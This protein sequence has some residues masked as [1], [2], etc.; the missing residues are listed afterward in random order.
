MNLSRIMNLT[1]I[2]FLQEEHNVTIYDVY[3][4]SDLMIKIYIYMVMATV[5]GAVKIVI[6]V[7]RIVSKYF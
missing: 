6:I 4:N 7:V 5:I 3:I 1:N 2:F